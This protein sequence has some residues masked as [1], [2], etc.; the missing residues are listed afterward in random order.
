VKGIDEP[1]EI[2]EVY[3]PGAAK[4][5][6]PAGAKKISSWPKMIPAAVLVLAGALA[7]VG[8]LAFERT[9]VTFEDLGVR[10]DTTDVMLDHKTRLQLEG[11][12][13]DHLRKCITPIEPGSHLIYYDVS[14]ITRYYSP[15]TVVRGKNL[16][17][18]HFDY[19]G[20]PGLSGDTAWEAKGKNEQTF[21]NSSDYSTYDDHLLKHDHK[22]SIAFTLKSAKGA[23]SRVPPGTRLSQK[24]TDLEWTMDWT[25]VLDGQKI[26]ADK[27]TVEHATDSADPTEGKRTLWEDARHRYVFSYR[28]SDTYAH[29]EIQAEYSEYK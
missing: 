1:L 2:F 5:R 6:P 13:E 18:P 12:P 8:Y 16:L 24:P 9:L 14:Y 11:S 3:R 27:L 25:V 22:V 19:F 7:V 26:S 4:P 29:G 21:T 28:L 20:L 15:L 17:R 10:T 23:A